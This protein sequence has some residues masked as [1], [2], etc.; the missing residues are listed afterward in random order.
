VSPGR[1]EHRKWNHPRE[2]RFYSQ[3]SRKGSAS[4]PFD[5]KHGAIDFGCIPCWVSV[6]DS[7]GANYI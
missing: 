1:A 3:E 4:K 6:V 2:R 7:P 5:L